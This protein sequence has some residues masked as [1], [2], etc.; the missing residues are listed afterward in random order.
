MVCIVLY[1]VTQPVFCE[2]KEKQ[3]ILEEKQLHLQCR[4]NSPTGKV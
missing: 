2:F 3:Q 1:K 4:L